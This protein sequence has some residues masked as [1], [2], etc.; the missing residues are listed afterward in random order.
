MTQDLNF[1]VIEGYS[2][3]SRD[4]LEAAGMSLASKLYGDMLLQR[5]PGA[6]YD[7]LFA[8]DSGVKMPL[9]KD[10]GGYKGIIWT[11]CNL[12]VNDAKN[13]CVTAQIQLAKDAYEVGVPSFGS[14]WALQI[15]VVAA[16]GK[17]EV[18]PNGRELGI[19]RKICQTPKAQNHPMFENKPRVFNAFISHDDMVTQMPSGSGVKATALAGNSFTNIQAAAITFKKGTFWATQYHP[20]YTL[21][22]MSR[23]LV[24]REQKATE[25]GF[26]KDHKD[27]VAYVEA[28]EA[29]SKNP[30][31][32]HLRWQLGIDDDVLDDDIRQCE[33]VNWINKMIGVS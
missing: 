19:A 21:Y 27:F 32:K 25:L 15:A 14:C 20:E 24:A 3:Q 29:L 1:L 12:C 7:V 13:S 4:E 16:G 33:F 11:G 17:V 10:L 28:M 22:E 8:S 6:T 2:K 26:F 31:Q 5:L 23:L 18:N 9:A 30:D